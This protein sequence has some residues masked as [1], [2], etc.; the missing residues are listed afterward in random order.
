[1]YL[2][3]H[4]LCFEFWLKKDFAQNRENFQLVMPK[5]HSVGQT[6]SRNLIS[7]GLKR[8]YFLSNFSGAIP[9]KIFG[10]RPYQASSTKRTLIWLKII[11]V[12]NSDLLNK[13]LRPTKF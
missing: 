4:N 12:S 8:V 7:G 11:P 10:F 3:T 5:T 2:Q 6:W 9:V 1:M 13:N